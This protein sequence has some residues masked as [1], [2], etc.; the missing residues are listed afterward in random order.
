M[1]YL[2]GTACLIAGQALLWTWVSSGE[3]WLLAVAVTLLVI[4]AL[5][6]APGNGKS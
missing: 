3:R 5:A 4:Y 1:R 6:M 2:T